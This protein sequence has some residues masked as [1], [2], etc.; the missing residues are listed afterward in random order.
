MKIFLALVTAASLAVA[1]DTAA[2][3]EHAPEQA[4][5]D[6]AITVM[7]ARPGLPPIERSL[8]PEQ[9]KQLHAAIET[10]RAK[11]TELNA[12]LLTARRAA[13]ETELAEK[14]DEAV[15]RTHTEAAAKAETEIALLNARAFATLRPQ[16][17]AEQISQIR[18]P[19]FTPG[20][21]GVGQRLQTIVAPTPAPAK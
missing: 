12:Q 15:F 4:K 16:L 7:G 21:P 13:L 20:A 5:M 2:V 9:R 17:T 8:T 19:T 10:N 6:R 11:I 18:N 1:A 3:P 14:F